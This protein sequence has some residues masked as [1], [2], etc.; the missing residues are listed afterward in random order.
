MGPPAV[1]RWL[2]PALLVVATPAAAQEERLCPNRPS[3]GTSTCTTDP[4]RV[5]AEVSAFDWQHDGGDRSLLIGDLAARMGV[6]LRTEVQLAW[7]PLSR[8]VSR[9]DGVR[10][11]AHGVG[12]VR[13]GLRQNLRNPDGEG[14]SIAVEGFVTLPTGTNGQGRGD[15]SAGLVVPV[16]ATVG[17]WSLAFTGEVD[18]DTNQSRSGRHVAESATLGIGRDLAEHL[19]AVVELAVQRD[20]DPADTDT[21]WLGA[22]SLAWEVRPRTQID[23][24][25][26]A[27]LNSQ[28][29]ELRI[30]MGGAVLF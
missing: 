11:V 27:G 9:A 26:A 16:S 19:T 18:A 2:A 5:L 20:E 13:L 21:Q 17:D 10:S 30:A 25:V 1:I 4:G 8:T 29:P 6:G 15:W 23:L 7:T 12:D 22:A 24:L 3:L 14:L 28:A